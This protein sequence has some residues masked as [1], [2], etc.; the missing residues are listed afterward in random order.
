MVLHI[1]KDDLKIDNTYP[2]TI[3]TDKQ[4]RLILVVQQVFS[5]SEHRF[6]VRYLYSN[7][8]EKFKGQNLKEQLWA[9]ARSTIELQ[10][11]G[12]MENEGTESRGL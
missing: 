8:Q 1:L 11:K 4:K 5:E 2:W 9:C 12:N 3:L 7:F 6:C 10:F